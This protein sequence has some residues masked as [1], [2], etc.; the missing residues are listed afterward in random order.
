MA[1]GLNH[2]LGFFEQQFF[3]CALIVG[4]KE[5]VKKMIMTVSFWRAFS[6][7]AG[8]EHKIACFDCSNRKENFS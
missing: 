7:I 8:A 3:R 5:P 6:V 2:P 1:M 4:G